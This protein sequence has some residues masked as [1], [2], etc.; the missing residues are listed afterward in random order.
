MSW[1]DLLAYLRTFSSLHTF[2]ERY[3]EDL[4]RHDGDIAVR[5]LNQLKEV[6]ASETGKPADKV[7]VEWPLALVLARRK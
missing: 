3:P 1:D 4:K 2:H 6:T 7:D 5:F